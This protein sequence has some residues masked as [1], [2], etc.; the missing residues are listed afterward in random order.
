MNLPTNTK[1]DKTKSDNYDKIND[2][3]NWLWKTS[4]DVYELLTDEEKN[5]FINIFLEKLNKIPNS[6]KVNYRVVS[7]I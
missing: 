5:N 1:L 7:V 6:L 3:L 4:T 2:R